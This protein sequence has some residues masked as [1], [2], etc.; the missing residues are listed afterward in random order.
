MIHDPIDLS[1]EVTPY[2]LP[3]YNLVILLFLLSMTSFCGFLSHIDKDY[4]CTFY[5]STTGKQFLCDNWL[6]GKTDKNRFYIFS[7]H[8]SYYK[9]INREIK[10]WLSQ[11][12]D[13]WE[14]D[15]EDFINMKM[16]GKIPTDLLP[17]SAL[18][19]LQLG[20]LKAGKKKSVE[21]R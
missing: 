2:D 20:D 3:L 5:S 9:S 12:W 15:Q 21:L 11:N 17:P 8:K 1:V 19:K 4:W 7:K 16:L 14:E 6:Y 10:E 13:K 18:K